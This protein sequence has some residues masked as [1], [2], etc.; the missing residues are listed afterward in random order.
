MTARLC[1][2]V[3]VVSSR[4]GRTVNSAQLCTTLRAQLPHQTGPD[5]TGPSTGQDRTVNRT[6]RQAR[7]LVAVSPALVA[8]VVAVRLVPVPVAVAVRRT[9][10]KE[11]AALA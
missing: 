2:T 5:R 7:P 8:A 11:F 3:A 6:I 1:L 9:W 4:N 10:P